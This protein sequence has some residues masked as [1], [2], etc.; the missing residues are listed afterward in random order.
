MTGIIKVQKGYLNP[1]KINIIFA[2]FYELLSTEQVAEV[3][4]SLRYFIY[5]WFLSSFLFESLCLYILYIT[6]TKMEY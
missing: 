6:F 4:R 1:K 3:V 2:I 5:T